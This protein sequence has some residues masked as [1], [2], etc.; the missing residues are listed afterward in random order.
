MFLSC[1]N[2]RAFKIIEAAEAEAGVPVLSSNLVFAWHLAR[3]S[4]LQAFGLPGT[5]G[6]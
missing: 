2:L 3:L 5:L 4:G 6:R 1:T